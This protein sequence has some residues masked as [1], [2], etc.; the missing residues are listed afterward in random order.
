MTVIYDVTRE[1]LGGE[2]R[3]Q[4]GYFVHF[5]APEGLPVLPKSVVFVIDISGSMYGRKIEQTKTAFETV[6]KEMSDSDE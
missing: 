6:L 1:K 2:I 4:D 5:F 3:T